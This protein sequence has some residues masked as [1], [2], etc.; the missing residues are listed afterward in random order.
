[1]SNTAALV[2]LGVSLVESLVVVIANIF[3]IF[4]FWQHRKRLKRTSYLL[5][6]LAVADLLVGLAEPITIITT[7]LTR[8]LEDREINSTTIA[9]KNILI[10]FQTAFC[11]VSIFFLVLIALERVYA[12]IWPLRHRVASAK[13]YIYCT[14]FTW[15]AGISVGVMSLLAAY[16]ILDLVP[17]IVTY[18]FISF[19]C[20]VSICVSYLAIRVASI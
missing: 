4:V 16:E 6:N 14:F 5:V 3:A 8:H 20:L 7:K 12:L 13:G 19:L 17:W 2:I 18:C 9:S 10:A 1:M 11:F 15:V